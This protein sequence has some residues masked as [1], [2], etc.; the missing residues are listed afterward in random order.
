MV[1]GKRKEYGQYIVSDPEIC[2]GELT[3]KGTRILVKDVLHYVALG[4]DWSW[5]IEA[6]DHS[7]GNEAITEAVSLANQAL[8]AATI[9][10]KRAA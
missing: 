3:F 8:M 7:I 5:I 9:K 1:A 6:Y 2:G 4:K 10:R